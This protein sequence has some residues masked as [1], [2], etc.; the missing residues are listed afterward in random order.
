MGC[1]SCSSFLWHTRKDSQAIQEEYGRAEWNRSKFILARMNL[2]IVIIQRIDNRWD[3]FTAGS[4]L[5]KK[6]GG[7]SNDSRIAQSVPQ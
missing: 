1:E 3:Y 4:H 6:I 2:N 5:V 7:K